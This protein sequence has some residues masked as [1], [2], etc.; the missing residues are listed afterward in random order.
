MTAMPPRVIA[1]AFGSLGCCKHTLNVYRGPSDTFARSVTTFEDPAGRLKPGA[2]ISKL[3]IYS[4]IADFSVD[5]GT[6]NE[7]SPFTR[8]VQSAMCVLLG[9]PMRVTATFAP[10]TGLQDAVAESGVTEVPGATLGGV[11][12]SPD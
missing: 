6:S 11:P 9:I 1:M 8:V 5:G 7:K 4:V 10:A 12:G 3:K 2:V